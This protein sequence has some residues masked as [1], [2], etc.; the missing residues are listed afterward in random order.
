MKRGIRNLLILLCLIIAGICIGFIVLTLMRRQQNGQIYNTI[1]ETVRTTE[2]AG[3]TETE[4]GVIPAESAAKSDGTVID[5]DAL[6]ELNPDI[7]AWIE[8]PGTAVDYPIVQSPTDD[9]YYLDHTIE[10]AAGYPGSI[11]TEGV[12][13]KDFSDFNTLIY[14]HDMRDGSMFKSLHDYQDESFLKEHPYV[15]VYLPEGRLTYRIFAAVVYSD[16][17]IMN[18]FDFDVADERQAFLDSLDTGDGRNVFDD[19]V[20]VTPEDH[21]ITLSTCIGDESTRRFLVEAVLEDEE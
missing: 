2:T 15:Y 19:T 21:I 20:E 12:N 17:H 13:A 9:S 3:E 1:Q 7:Y 8:I 10:G 5:F 16:R 18:T 6:K 11:Y 14:G 4:E